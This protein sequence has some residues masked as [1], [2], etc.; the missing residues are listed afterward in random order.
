MNHPALPQ[1]QKDDLPKLSMLE[2]LKFCDL[3]DQAVQNSYLNSEAKRHLL[4]ANEELRTHCAELLW[5]LK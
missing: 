2:V 1:L 3:W 5:E 4:K